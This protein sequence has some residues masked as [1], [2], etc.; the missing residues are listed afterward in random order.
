MLSM[1]SAIMC[2]LRL[3]LCFLVFFL[4]CF[5]ERQSGFRT[6]RGEASYSAYRD[7]F[8]PNTRANQALMALLCV[9]WSA[10]CI[11]PRWPYFFFFA[12]IRFRLANVAP[13]ADSDGAIIVA[14]A[15]S[16]N[17]SASTVGGRGFKAPAW[18]PVADSGG[19][20]STVALLRAH[21]RGLG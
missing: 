8:Y 4:I 16:G 1:L 3:I 7:L 17:P 18:L 15:G 2:F 6:N 14:N 5:V 13:L 19:P 21:L 11:W 20:H 9:N 12:A 10:L